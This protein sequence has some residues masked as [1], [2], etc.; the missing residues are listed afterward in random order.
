[1]EYKTEKDLYRPT[2]IIKLLLSEPEEYL[3]K[4]DATDIGVK[5]LV[6]NR[7]KSKY[8]KTRWG[9]EE[10]RMPDGTVKRYIPKTKLFLWED[11]PD[12]RGRPLQNQKGVSHE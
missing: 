12:Y 1:M 5:S 11:N 4:E 8:A 3:R 7:F 6:N 9:V 2:D 10:V